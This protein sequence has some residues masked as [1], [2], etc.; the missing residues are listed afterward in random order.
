MDCTTIV[1]TLSGS[2]LFGHEKGA[3]T[4]ADRP[5]AGAFAAANG[6]TLFLDEIGELPLGLQA[7]LLR[8]LQEHTYKRVGGDAWAHSEFRL[9]SATNRDLVADQAQG[10]FRSDLYHR[11]A[12]GVV[13]LPPLRERTEDVEDLFAHFLREAMGTPAVTVSKPVLSMLRGRAFP[14]NLRELRQLAQ[15]VAARHPGVG[16]ITPGDV[17]PTERPS[18]FAVPR[19]SAHRLLAE[20][21]RDCLRAGISLRD[22]KSTVGDLA[23]DIALADSGGNA[24]EAAALLGVTDRA[25]Q[26][27]K[28]DRRAE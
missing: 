28:R 11:I 5:R 3:F 13:R 27:R 15:A 12:S 1:P 6:G 2:E 16:P 18:G 17:P 23:V 4:G 24:H 14:G 22:L 25:V 9:V 8:V 26:L 20:A 21:V 7:E 19:V 10:L